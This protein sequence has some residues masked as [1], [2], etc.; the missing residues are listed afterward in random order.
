MRKVKGAG[1]RRC[2]HGNETPPIHEGANTWIATV[3]GAGLPVRSV[4]C[5]INDWKFCIVWLMFS[6]QSMAASEGASDL[7]GKDSARSPYC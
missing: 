5:I 2:T 7:V 4:P 6:V 3:G 1:L